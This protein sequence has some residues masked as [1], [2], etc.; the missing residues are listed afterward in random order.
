MGSV[1]EIPGSF[2][3]GDA[4]RAADVGVCCAGWGRSGCVAEGGHE[5]KEGRRRMS[6]SVRLNGWPAS[7]TGA[8]RDCSREC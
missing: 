6:R 4:G 2:A 8:Y 7:P 1:I 3:P 5:S